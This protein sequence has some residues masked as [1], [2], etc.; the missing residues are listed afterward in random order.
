MVGTPLNHL[1]Q[2]TTQ[3]L[4]DCRQSMNQ[5]DTVKGAA[6]AK[7]TISA[8]QAEHLLK[9]ME[10]LVDTK[11]QLTNDIASS[12]ISYIDP[13]VLNAMK[14]AIDMAISNPIDAKVNQIYFSIFGYNSALWQVLKEMQKLLKTVEFLD[15][16]KGKKVMKVN[17]S[18]RLRRKKPN[19]KDVFDEQEKE[20]K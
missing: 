16:P 10:T 18:P 8:D 20:E 5:T 1:M 4:Y 9:L 13:K 14:A 6:A 11:I 3:A 19:E 15:E 17:K 2:A 7:Q 12:R